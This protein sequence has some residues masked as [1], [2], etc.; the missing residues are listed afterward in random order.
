VDEQRV[1]D[2]VGET[3]S[4]YNDLQKINKDIEAQDR[5][6][7]NLGRFKGNEQKIIAAQEE[8]KRLEERKQK[9]QVDIGKLQADGRAAQEQ[10]SGKNAQ[11]NAFD[12]ITKAD[13]DATQALRKINE[14]RVKQENEYKQ[15][16]KPTKQQEE[17]FKQQDKALLK[18]YTEKE[19]EYWR[20]KGKEFQRLAQEAGASSEKGD[21][22]KRAALEAQKK[23]N[24]VRESLRVLL[25]PNELVNPKGASKKG[26]A[27]SPTDDLMNELRGTEKDLLKAHNTLENINSSVITIG[28][29]R[30][31]ATRE[32]DQIIE[33]DR[34]YKKV[35]TPADREKAIEALTQKKLIEEVIKEQKALMPRVEQSRH[36][37]EVMQERLASGDFDKQPSNKLENKALKDLEKIIRLSP[38]A[39]EAYKELAA[40]QKEYQE[41]AAKLDVGN[42]VMEKERELRDLRIQLIEDPV[43]RQA[44]A[45]VESIEIEDRKYARIREAAVRANQ[46]ITRLDAIHADFLKGKI[47]QMSAGD[48]EALRKLRIDAIQDHLDRERRAAQEEINIAR[49]TYEMKREIAATKGFDTSKMDAD[50]AER[51][52]LMIGKFMQGNEQRVA[53][54]RISTIA[55]ARERLLAEQQKEINDVRAKYTQY[56]LLAQD[57]SDAIVRI[58]EQETEELDLLNRRQAEEA[59]RPLERLVTEWKDTETQIGQIQADVASS[60]VDML[61]EGLGEGELKIGDWTKRVLLMIANMQLKQALADPLNT[62]ISGITDSIRG[63][64]PQAQ[65]ASMPAL[66]IENMDDFDRNLG[67]SSNALDEMANQGVAQ[68]AQATAQSAITETQA[69]TGTQFFTNAIYQA[70]SAAQAFAAQVGASS[71]MSAASGIAGA[72][73]SGF[74]DYGAGMDMAYMEGPFFADGGIMDPALGKVPLRKYARGGVANRPQAAIYGEGDSPEAFVPLPDGRSIPVT[75]QGQA[76]SVVVNVINQSGTPVNAEQT[77]PRFDGKQMVLDVVLTAVNQPGPFRDG[78]KGAM[79]G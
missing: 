47:D 16:A 11:R 37:L 26:P 39:S 56:L 29:L 72:I 25:S 19:A 24:Q 34:R 7:A 48:E 17:Q 53:D 76:P 52:R 63:V 6:I 32:I 64:N 74:G 49:R 67:I 45:A 14:L 23:E 54:M 78:M 55:N 57:N 73:S 71:G 40:A 77:Q 42:Y 70:A 59:K 27:K 9:I 43:Q 21:A 69:T 3:T 30:E 10:L 65:A 22:Y 44:T 12:L 46:D 5:T 41:N 13:E 28:Q 20:D 51:E 60:F 38:E 75:M 35:Y 15:I 4:R 62:I 66:S 1:K 61:T 36:D 18:Q 50:Q 31:Q 58:K 68:A 33:Q 79:R 2:V 8:R